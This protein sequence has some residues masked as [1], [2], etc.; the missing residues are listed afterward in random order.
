MSRLNSSALWEFFQKLDNEKKAKCNSCGEIYSFKTSTANLKMH[1]K[2]K[3]PHAYTCVCTAQSTSR[4]PEQSHK[5]EPPGDVQPQPSSS[6][7]DAASASTSTAA[8]TIP[9]YRS[10][11]QRIDSYGIS[12]KVTVTKK[13]QIDNDLAD[14]FIDSYHPFSLV[15][16]R[17]FKKFAKHIPGTSYR[18]EKLFLTF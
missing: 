18:R 16:E 17:A 7:S 9:L 2:R 3:H 8:S 4:A 6:S 11:Q 5:Q 1:L 14:L 10:A 12:K 15:E 13:R